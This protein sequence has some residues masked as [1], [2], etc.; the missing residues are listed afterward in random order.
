[1]EG[2]LRKIYRDLSYGFIDADRKS[3]FFHRSDFDGSWGELCTDLENGQSIY[4]EFEPT[5]GPKGLRAA[6]VKL[7][8]V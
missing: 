1:M 8:D 6:E 2:R 5:S 3:Y 4:L 7:R